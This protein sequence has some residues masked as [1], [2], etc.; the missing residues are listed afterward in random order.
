MTHCDPDI[1]DTSTDTLVSDS[2]TDT[3]LDSD[4]DSGSNAESDHSDNWLDQFMEWDASLDEE[5]E[6]PILLVVSRT[7]TLCL[8]LADSLQVRIAQDFILRWLPLAG[9]ACLNLPTHL[10]LCHTMRVHDPDTDCNV[11]I[12][13][14]YTSERRTDLA[15]RFMSSPL[16][17]I[18]SWKTCRATDIILYFTMLAFE[19]PLNGAKVVSPGLYCAFGTTH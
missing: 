1:S 18:D 15:V 3:R 10:L 11:L 19:E 12:S 2:E 17:A 4:S 9:S 5:S 14:A 8:Q 16:V 7:Q 13:R 6:L